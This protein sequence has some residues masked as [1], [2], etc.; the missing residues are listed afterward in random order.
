MGKAKLYPG[1][2][3]QAHDDGTHESRARPNASTG[4]ER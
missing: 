1:T 2:I 3:A 4:V